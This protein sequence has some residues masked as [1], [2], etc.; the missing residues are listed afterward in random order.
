[1][2]QRSEKRPRDTCSTGLEE[3]GL[4][5]KQVVVVKKSRIGQS[6]SIGF[7]LDLLKLISS[8]DRKVFTIDPL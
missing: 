3:K 8:P 4:E 5:E 1:M 6:W 2:R 7:F